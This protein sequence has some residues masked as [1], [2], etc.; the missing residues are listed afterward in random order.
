V[1]LEPKSS[2][3]GCADE[4]GGVDFH[5][6]LLRIFEGALTGNDFFECA[7]DSTSSPVAA[8]V[9]TSV[10]LTLT[11]VLLLNM[12]IAMCAPLPHTQP[13]SLIPLD[14]LQIYPVRRILV[15]CPPTHVAHQ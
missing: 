7:R 4:L 8:W 11:A 9:L 1:L 15:C 2:I 10:Y 3:A 12:L 6:T 13:H 14:I 5:T